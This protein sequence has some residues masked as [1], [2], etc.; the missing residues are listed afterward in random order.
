MKKDGVIK[1]AN[2]DCMA[3]MSETCNHVAV[4]LFRVEAAV[5]LGLS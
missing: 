4:L 3:G 2:C 1:S 5:R